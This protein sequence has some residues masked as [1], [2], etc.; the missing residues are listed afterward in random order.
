MRG[1]DQWL[2]RVGKEEPQAEAA[3]LHPQVKLCTSSVNGLAE[4]S[5]SKTQEGEQPCTPLKPRDF[6]RC[7]PAPPL[8]QELVDGSGW[9]V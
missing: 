2:L 8:L 7:E 9:P 5:L 4:F 6:T 3:V 1:A